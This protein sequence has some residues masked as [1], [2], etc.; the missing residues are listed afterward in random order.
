MI[1][2]DENDLVYMN[3]S[4]KYQA[5]VDDVR[6]KEANGQPVLIGT[7]SIEFF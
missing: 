4:D 1:R 5:I 2:R 6:S 7:A 3:L